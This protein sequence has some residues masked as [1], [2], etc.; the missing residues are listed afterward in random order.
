MIKVPERQKNKGFLDNVADKVFLRWEEEK[1]LENVGLEGDIELEW[2][3]GVGFINKPTKMVGFIQIGL[4]F[5]TI[6]IS[7]AWRSF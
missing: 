4:I 7:K 3:K 6:K 1:T 2:W 5:W